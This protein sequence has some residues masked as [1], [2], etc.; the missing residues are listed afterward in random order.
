MT[1]TS[2]LL[3]QAANGDGHAMNALLD[4]HRGRLKRMVAVRMDRRIASRIDPSDI[5]QESLAEAVVKFE[6]YANERPVA[7]YP[8]LR[9]ITWQRLVKT[10]RSH[11]GTSKRST[12][13]E[14]QGEL[15]L[16]DDSVVQLIDRLV[17]P[18]ESP[19]QQAVNHEMQR[20][21]REALNQMKKHDR[22]ILVLR[23]LEQLSMHEIAEVIGISEAAVRQRHV[24]ALHRL[25]ND[26]DPG[27]EEQR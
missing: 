6:E 22:E 24:R 21:V 16:P 9:Q 19:T 26:L 11:I 4:K 8:W 13:Q 3:K 10:H 15:E 27:S 7:F 12:E 5:V 1:D 17:S 18:D 23:Y 20:R 2:L 14:H 25:Q